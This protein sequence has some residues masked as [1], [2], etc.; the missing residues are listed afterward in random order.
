MESCATEV[1]IDVIV[2]R[3]IIEVTNEQYGHTKEMKS[4]T[5]THQNTG[6]RRAFPLKTS[7]KISLSKRFD[8]KS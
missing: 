1:L 4:I 5:K 8:E 6:K 7:S 3:N 2:W